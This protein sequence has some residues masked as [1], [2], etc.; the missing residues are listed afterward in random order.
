MLISILFATFILR[1]GYMG[2][3]GMN[4]T[5]G[6]E[7]TS[8]LVVLLYIRRTP[9]LPIITHFLISSYDRSGV[10]SSQSRSATK[11][12]FCKQMIQYIA[13]LIRFTTRMWNN[14]EQQLMDYAGACI[15][16]M[17]IIYISTSVLPAPKVVELL[18]ETIV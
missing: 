16:C 13:M 4:Q 12:Q 8:N 6:F 9:L 5:G 10:T 1:D 18:S 7:G 17:N 14:R 3:K 11:K 15:A 2:S